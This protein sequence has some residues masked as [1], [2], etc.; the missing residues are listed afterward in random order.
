MM[1][2]LLLTLPLFVQDAGAP[3]RH[4]I[5]VLSTEDLILATYRPMHVQTGD[6]ANAVRS[7]MGRFYHTEE[8]GGRSAQPISNTSQVG[9]LVLLFD[10]PAYVDEMMSLCKS[11]DAAPEAIAAPETF[12]YRTR[13]ISVERAERALRPLRDRLQLSFDKDGGR[14]VASGEKSELERL[15]KMLVE[16]DVPDP[17][18][19]VSCYILK[20]EVGGAS[21]PSALLPQD[22]VDDLGKLLPQFSFE[23]EGFALL[24]A[25]IA[26]GRHLRVAT[27]AGEEGDFTLTFEVGAYDDEHGLLSAEKCRL[28]VKKGDRNSEVFSTDTVLRAGEYTVLGATGK[29]PVLLVVRLDKI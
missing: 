19:M 29:E 16:T 5:P 17:R 3:E 2:S 20:G 15:E 25:S 4:Q 7:T 10:T 24:Q 28:S 18:V 8:R 22:L 26:P 14:L 13:Y 23:A 11:I 9:S 1:L 21:R 27:E 6:L 12:T